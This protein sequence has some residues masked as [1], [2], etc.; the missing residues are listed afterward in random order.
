MNILEQICADKR[1]EIAE[2]KKSQTLEELQSTFT[3]RGKRPDFVD[4]LRATPMG[5][6]A[7]VKRKSPSAG[8]IREPFSPSEIAKAYEANGAS[9]VSCLMDHKYFGGGAA[10]FSEVRHAIEL[11]MLYKE[12]VVDSWQIAHAKTMGASAVLLIVG[13]LM[14]AELSAFIEEVRALE[15]QPLV[16]VHDRVE[17]QRAIDAGSD[18]IG[19]NNRNLKTFVTTLDT[20]FELAAMA[21]MGCTLVSE[22]GIRTPEDVVQLKEAGAHA[23]LVGESLLRE[24][25]PGKAA[26]DLLSRIH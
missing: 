21:P 2:R 26:A 18:C 17:M 25:D 3:D 12:F 22:S 23:I 8:L 15:L 1:A 10:D 14:D 9:A 6:I 19:I 4:A 16:E 24:D 7:E 13:A 20:T 11:P 5:L